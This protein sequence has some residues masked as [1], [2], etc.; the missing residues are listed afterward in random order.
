MTDETNLSTGDDVDVTSASET[1]KGIDATSASEEVKTPPATSAEDG[2]D[3]SGKDANEEVDYAK[4]A[5]PEGFEIDDAMLSEATPLLKDLKVGK[6][7]A[8]KLFKMGAGLIQNFQEKQAQAWEKQQKDWHD[9][10]MNDPVISLAENRAIAARAYKEL[11]T[12]GLK[13]VVDQF[14]LGNHPEVVRHFYNLGTKMQDDKLVLASGSGVAD[15]TLGQTL[16]S[17]K[18][19]KK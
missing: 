5:M 10:A 16:Y 8:E 15:K 18:Y 4:V 17:D 9:T 12:D 14:G 11:A 7:N 6:E 3:A 13:A 1:D 2:K 19:D